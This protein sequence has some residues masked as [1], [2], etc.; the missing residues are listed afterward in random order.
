MSNFDN[1][2]HKDLFALF[3]L[4]ACSSEAYEDYAET[5]E[6]YLETCIEMVIKD[7]YLLWE[8]RTIHQERKGYGGYTDQCNFNN[9]GMMLVHE[10]IGNY[11]CIV[12]FVD[13]GE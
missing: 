6:C 9:Y 12:Y 4:K 7:Y 13:E 1:D 5:L 10:Q 11:K 3:I 8:D 2:L